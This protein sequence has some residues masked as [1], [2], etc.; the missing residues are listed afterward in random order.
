MGVTLNSKNY[1]CD[2]GY[3]GF[4]RLRTTVAGLVGPDLGDHYK[5]LDEPMLVKR[6]VFEMLLQFIRQGLIISPCLFI[7]QKIQNGQTS[8]YPACSC[9]YARCT[10]RPGTFF[11]VAS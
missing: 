11:P 4:N 10:I 2:F 5:K 9:L 1:E 6:E 8:L 3:D 7:F